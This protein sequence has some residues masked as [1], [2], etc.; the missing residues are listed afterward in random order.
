MK[1]TRAVLLMAYGG[2]N[3]LDDVEPYLLDVRGG[4]QTPRELIEEIRERYAAIGGK[5]PLL[6][7]T[8]SQARALE[9]ELNRNGQHKFQVFVGMRHW[10]PYIHETIREI[11]QKGIR[12]LITVCMTPFESRMSTGAYYEQLKKAIDSEDIEEDWRQNLSLF[13]IGAWYSHPL[14]VKAAAVN[15]K[16]SMEEILALGQHKPFVVFTAHSLPAAL[17]NQGDPY[18]KQFAELSRLVAEEAG[19][20]TE[21]WTYCFQSAGAAAGRWLGPTLEETINRLSATG[22]TTILVSAIG[23]LCDHVEVLFDIDIEAKKFAEKKGV[24]LYRTPSMNSNPLFIK[25]MASILLSGDYRY[26]DYQK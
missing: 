2:P 6:E 15:L 25:A 26:G 17:A 14:F 4:R 20:R 10:K 9:E 8:C 7:M 18:E 19:L 23:F 3:N 16:N 12:E 24:T 1:D 11:A 13:Q 21:E 22:Y 5:S